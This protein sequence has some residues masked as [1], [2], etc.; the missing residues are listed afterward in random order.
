MGCWGTGI[1]DDDLALDVRDLY[2]ELIKKGYKDN[3]VTAK[4]LELYKESI[5]DADDGIIIYSA[6]A[7]LQ[8]SKGSLI[9][10]VKNKVASLIKAKQGLQR[11]KEND[12]SDYNVRL[13]VLKKLLDFVTRGQSS[14]MEPCDT[15][16]VECDP[17]LYSVYKLSDRGGNVVYIGSTAFPEKRFRYMN[18]VVMNETKSPKSMFGFLQTSVTPE[19]AFWSWF[20]Q[21]EQRL[22]QEVDSHGSAIDELFERLNIIQPQLT[23]EF[24]QTNDGKK[25]LAISADGNSELFPYVIKLYNEPKLLS[26]WVIYPFRQR[27]DSISKVALRMG[28]LNI[29]AENILFISRENGNRIELGICVRHI[30]SVNDP[31]IGAIFLLLDSAIGEYDV[32]SKIG[33]IDVKPYSALKDTAHLMP[34][35]ELVE[36]VDRFK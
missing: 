16:V 36:I 22:Y 28:N 13:R 25:I 24:G 17:L 29:D 1:F 8:L 21:N 3:Q 26:K 18:Y 6:L 15:N 20:S 32:V 11:W 7:A 33:K 23:A 5:E 4:V 14:A 34:L 30:E 19:E 35:E 10:E 27:M 12:K 2:D 31:I 9:T